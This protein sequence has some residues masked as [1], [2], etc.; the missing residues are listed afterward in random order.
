MQTANEVNDEYLDEWEK[1]FGVQVK[2]DKPEE[3]VQEVEEESQEEQE[4]EVEEEVST[5]EEP[6]ES[7]SPQQE[8]AEEQPAEQKEKS[9]D[10]EYRE[11][12]DSQPNEELKEKAR[13]IVQG[14]KSADGRT[15]ALHR[16]LNAREQL[17]KQLHQRQSQHTQE[18][19]A[20]TSARQ[21]EPAQQKNQ[22]LPEKVRAL[23][24]KNPEAAEIIEQIAQYHS[25]KSVK[26]MQELVDSRLG[27][28]EQDREVQQKQQEW[29]K[30]EDKAKDLFSPYGLTA[31]Q[32][33]QSEDFQAWLQLKQAEEPGIYKLYETAEDADTAFLVL[34]KYE[35]EYREAAKAAGIDESEDNSS[36][37]KGD[38]IRNR[39]QKN[40]AGGAGLKPSRAK[41]PTT[42]TSNL[43]YNEEF[44]LIWGNKGKKT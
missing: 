12:I 38:E 19:A 7:D 41:S 43:S 14:L 18:P 33:A 34:E 1:Q 44:D 10:D 2:P 16:Q 11:F 30:V 37:N 8:G 20:P 29:Q 36:H 9:K 4:P 5:E 21:G 35:H 22:E 6:T 3:N 23:K 26:Q 39:R 25:D 31:A 27:T 40:K 15:S 24:E 28:I 32:V 42:D 13:K 17:I